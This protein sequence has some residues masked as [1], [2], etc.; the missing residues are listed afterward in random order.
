MDGSDDSA[1]LDFD[2]FYRSTRDRL[3]IQLTA[4][5][6]D[7]AEAIDHVQEAFI[8]AWSRWDRVS[9]LE[10]PEAWVRRVA[11]NL[12]V[13]RF[14]RARRLVFGS[15]QL[16]GAVEFE[17]GQ[18]DLVAALAQLPAPERAAL[19]LKHQVGL[20]VAEIAI[21][22]QAPEGTVKSWLSRGRT[23]LAAALKEELDEAR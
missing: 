21:E 3:A 19:V 1:T 16:D 5:T 18:A 2:G 7:A 13:S 12:A 22:M 9:A 8:R 11:Y 23:R 15:V 14:R 17:P 6:G 4:M 10:D 20:S